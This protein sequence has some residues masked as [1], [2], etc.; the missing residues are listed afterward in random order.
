MADPDTDTDNTLFYLYVNEDFFNIPGDEAK[1][2][3]WST[4]ELVWRI[5]GHGRKMLI[6][7]FLKFPG[8]WQHKHEAAKFIAAAF[9]QTHFAH[10]HFENDE[11]FR[12]NCNDIMN[13]AF[14]LASKGNKWYLRFNEIDRFHWMNS[15]DDMLEVNTWI[16]EL[17]RGS[18]SQNPLPHGC[19]SFRDSM[20]I[21]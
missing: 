13:A 20:T 11:P 18:V 17:E 7:G 21:E 1:K 12:C 14:Y 19:E 16:A 4:S 6:A 10:L 8:L 9:T 3:L 2:C 5:Q 15:W